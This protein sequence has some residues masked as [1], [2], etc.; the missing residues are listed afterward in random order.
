MTDFITSGLRTVEME[1][2]AV[3]QLTPR[4]NQN[5]VLA[6]E[7]ILACQ[8]R[9]VVT[10]MGKSGHIGNKIAATLASTGTPAFFVHPGEASHGDLGMITK[11]DV[12]IAISNSG[13]TSEVTR[14][15]PLII[16][17]G[18]PLISMTGDANSPL[19]QAACAHLDVSVTTEACPLNLAPT[20]STTVTLV[21]GDALAIALLEARG[22]SAEDFAFSHPGGTLGRKLLLRVCDIMHKDDDVP[23]VMIDQPL[24][25]A[26]LEMTQKGFGMTTVIS[27][28]KKLLGIFTDGDLRRAIDQKVNIASTTMANVMSPNPKTI[29]QDILAVEA[30]TIMESTAITALVVEDEKGHPTGV[31]HLHDILRAGVV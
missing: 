2:Q 17:L 29:N 24:Q 28:E 9:V 31:L 26:L 6:C 30:L 27:K 23:K 25:D 21:M 3:S 1:A 11:A 13:S 22:F 5:F 16:R 20:T 7:T 8:G 12:V 19:S 10:G 14:L 18:I 15:L 4:I